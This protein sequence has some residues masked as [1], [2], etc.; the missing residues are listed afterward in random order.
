MSNAERLNEEG[1]ACFRLGQYEKAVV[2]YKLA[3]TIHAKNSDPRA[4]VC[5]G[6]LAAAA[7][8]ME[9]YTDAQEAADTAL[10]LDY[11]LIKARYRR[12]MA[13]RGLGHNMHSIVDLSTVLVLDPKNTAAR[14]NL[15]QG[16]KVHVDSKLRAISTGDLLEVDDPPAYGTHLTAPKPEGYTLPPILP[17]ELS[18]A[19]PT[20]KPEDVKLGC[21]GC[22]VMQPRKKVKR[23]EKC[24]VA[25]YCDT[26]CQRK[27][28]P[29]HK[30]ICPVF[31]EHG[32]L[33]ELSA[34]LNRHIHMRELMRAYA[35]VVLGLL[36]DTPFPVP[37]VVIFQVELFPIPKS[38]KRR[39]GIRRIQVVPLVALGDVVVARY[40][41]TCREMVAEN[42]DMRPLCCM[43]CPNISRAPDNYASYDVAAVFPNEIHRMKQRGVEQVNSPIFGRLPLKMDLENIFR[44]LEDELEG[45]INN[46][47][48]LRE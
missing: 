13:L 22:T 48:R 15:I 32:V 35:I 46:F 37:A 26:S 41:S 45:D 29:R 20:T 38:S 36:G 34:K 31:A 19:E 11:T 42:P 23:C 7:L 5:Y 21:S 39:L 16:L 4:A 40:E 12:A 25:V 1:G 6:N 28:W 9:G 14:S 24:R 8:K 47:Y 44:A 30:K 43:V 2:A 27:D 33:I 17:I 18:Q 10:Q 3:A